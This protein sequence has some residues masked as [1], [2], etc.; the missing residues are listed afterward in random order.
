MSDKD[1]DYIVKVERAIKEKYG[2]EAIQN[3]RKFWN[4]E[5]EERYLKDL[6][7]FYNR[8]TESDSKDK[9]GEIYV[10]RKLLERKSNR[11]CPVC[12]KYSF[13]GKDD[14]YMN[15]FSCC[16]DCYIQYVEGREERWSSGWRP[17]KNTMAIMK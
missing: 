15:K 16:F 8:E 11:K 13:E 3:P 1:F 17:D 7:E 4:K 12:G 6:K 9:V 5:K 2:E 14:L 10:S